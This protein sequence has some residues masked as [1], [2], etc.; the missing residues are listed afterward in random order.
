MFIFEAF[1]LRFQGL[2]IVQ[3][4]ETA[5]LEV[6]N[7]VVDFCDRRRRFTSLSEGVTRFFILFRLHYQK[8]VE[9][10]KPSQVANRTN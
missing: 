6:V 8:I 3:L 10:K 4:L 9:R 5:F 7:E 1:E 2:Q